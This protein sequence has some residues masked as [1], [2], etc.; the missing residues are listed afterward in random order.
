MNKR[1][2]SFYDDSGKFI[3]SS[4]CEEAILP[5]I[6]E[7][8]A[9]IPGQHFVEGDWFDKAMYV[10]D[11]EVTP[12][13]ENPAALNGLILSNLPIPSVIRINHADYPCT[14]ASAT[15]TFNH[16]GTYKVIIKSW[17]YLEKEFLIDYPTL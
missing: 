13:P 10:L 1:Y 12:Q 3:G 7:E 4:S 5:M 14:E 2:L 8:T 15:L 9:K 11:G 16:P 17:P 6:M